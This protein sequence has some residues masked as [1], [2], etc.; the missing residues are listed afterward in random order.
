MRIAYKIV[1]PTIAIV[2]TIVASVAFT[3]TRSLER[4]LFEE[5]YLS[6]AES[7]RAHAASILSEADIVDPSTPDARTRFALFE[8]ENQHA[9]VARIT[10]WGTDHRVIYSDL[11]SIIGMKTQDVAEIDR[12]FLEGKP[13][14]IIREKDERM[15]RQSNAGQFLD[16]FVPITR[17]DTHAVVEVHS[18]INAI[19]R[20]IR[21]VTRSVE[22]TLIGG[23]LLMFLMLTLILN[24]FV[25]RPVRM[26]AEAADR[27]A[28]GDYATPVAV[29]TGDEM[30]LFS[31]TFDTMRIK[32]SEFVGTLE[33]AVKERTIE[34]EEA[35]AELA[36]SISSLP[37]G[38]GLF[39]LDGKMLQSNRNLS[40][41]LDAP[42]IAHAS[43][44]EHLFGDN[45][46][47]N[48]Y[49]CSCRE[50]CD[51]SDIKEILV[52][53]KFLRCFV[54]P[55]T[56]LTDTTAILGVAVLVEDITE[57]KLLERAKDEFFAVASHELRTPLT[58]I[59]GNSELL[60]G[61]E[62]EERSTPE[63]LGMVADI[64]EAS[65]RLIKIVN[66]FLDVS[67]M[68][69]GGAIFKQE[70]FDI[71]DVLRSTMNELS[72]LARGRK[73]ALN[74]DGVWPETLLVM[75]DR[76]RTKQVAINL[77]ANGLKFTRK[78]S[79]S[80]SLE[81]EGDFAVVRVRDTG[82]GIAEKEQ[83]LLFRKFQQAQK[84]MFARDISQSTGLGLYISKLAVEKMGGTIALEHSEVGKGCT[85]RFTIPLAR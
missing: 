7:V 34:L 17:G 40:R 16:I 56:R 12:A 60:E 45:F 11:G 49:L 41:L 50:G 31:R 61:M 25:L 15:P 33:R 27:I 10:V 77:I 6:V 28:G 20:P 2:A 63:A 80:V 58:A 43:D 8:R 22:Y 69:Q 68:E 57:S 4:A 32:V 42:A 48:A 65:A 70:S 74:E 47:L 78:G 64:A 82:P 9:S 14:F 3:T 13:F 62:P 18:V 23:G 59:R 54:I 44:I 39:A 84:D 5:E 46:S 53:G 51:T 37:L 72:A 52:E 29:H 75:A 30:E 83:P 67:R 55:V 1:I 36:A 71:V 66:D 19:L 24:Y 38:F 85:F 76:D 79:V 73:I 81:W 35:R 21:D 26:L